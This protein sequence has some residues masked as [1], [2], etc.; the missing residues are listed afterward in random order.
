MAGK[1]ETLKFIK[2]NIK[3]KFSISDS[4]KV[5][6]FLGVYYKW[7]HNVKGTY[8]KMTMETDVKG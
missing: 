3:E 4:G 6:K 8:E 2:L 7:V 5:K 1:Q